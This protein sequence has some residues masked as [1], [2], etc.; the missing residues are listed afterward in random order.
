MLASL[1]NNIRE[2]FQLY[3]KVHGLEI[4]INDEG[5]YI[6]HHVTLQKDR[7]VINVAAHGT[8]HSFES[9][10]E[11][12]SSDCLLNITLSGRGILHKKIEGVMPEKDT[13]LIQQVL[14]NAR[15]DDFYVQTR[16]AYQ[17]YYVSLIRKNVLDSLFTQLNQLGY[18]IGSVQLGGAGLRVLP[19]LFE[20]IDN[21]QNPLHIG[22]H[23]LSFSD[24][25]ILDQY[26]YKKSENEERFQLGEEAL[27]A[28][29]V[30][31]YLM[32]LQTF[33]PEGF[34]E[35]LDYAAARACKKEY[36]EKQ[37]FKPLLYGSAGLVLLI[38]M[39][40]FILFSHY[41]QQQN[42]LG[43]KSG[44]Y[45]RMAGKLDSLKTTVR[46]KETFLKNAGWLAP[47]RLSFY[48]D[49]IARSV[50]SSIQLTALNI[51][52]MDEAAMKEERR[53]VFSPGNIYIKGTCHNAIYVNRWMKKL[54]QFSW[55]SQVSL[56]D[57]SHD[58]RG[59]KGKFYIETSLKVYSSQTKKQAN[60]E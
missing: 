19:G 54:N 8:S 39:V 59:D 31:P 26:V 56:R 44:Y 52:P 48:A 3:K 25:G 7:S 29:Y 9:L 50:P 2:K 11:Q 32:A 55:L 36:K 4:V 60:D 38:L 46:K 22:S 18:F 42:E 47:S 33:L 23:Q 41:E 21:R 12:L 5:Q 10:P 28:C 15:P 14:P 24:E 37:Y 6:L 20:N 53:Y 51:N 49:R 30:L 34:T 27:T 58:F 57:Y 1:K 16:E 17:G 40:N 13:A 35:T 43:S 45:S